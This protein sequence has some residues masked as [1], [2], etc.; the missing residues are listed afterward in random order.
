M[1]KAIV[2]NMSNTGLGVARSLGRQN[3]PVVGLDHNKS[4]AGFSSKFCREKI[5]VADPDLDPAN[6]LDQLEKFSK[7]NPEKAVL[8]PT[9]DRYVSFISAYRNKLSKNFLFNIP[10]PDLLNSI[11]DKRKQYELAE[12]FNIPLSISVYPDK[13]GDIGIVNEKL[14][15][16]LF[17]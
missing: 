4:A 1:H 11:V 2:L 5:I 17:I 13:P 7:N 9:S 12:R 8:L 15:F 16:P 3:I 6:C 14:N 10:D